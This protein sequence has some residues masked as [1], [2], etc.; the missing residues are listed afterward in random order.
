MIQKT[1]EHKDTQDKT[2][3]RSSVFVSGMKTQSRNTD[4]FADSCRFLIKTVDLQL[5]NN[6]NKSLTL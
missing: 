6:T 2:N 5:T 1:Q 3:K 4:H